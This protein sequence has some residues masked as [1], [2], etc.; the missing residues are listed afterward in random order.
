MRLKDSDARRAHHCP[1][2][3]VSVLDAS[4]D[5]EAAAVLVEQTHRARHLMR[6][7]AP[8]DSVASRMH[9][10]SHVTSVY[11]APDHCVQHPG[12]EDHH[13][14]WALICARLADGMLQA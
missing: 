1:S 2:V 10:V 13:G 11:E 8:D 12:R 14:A 6:P 7:I 4:P 5:C 9:S 3:Q